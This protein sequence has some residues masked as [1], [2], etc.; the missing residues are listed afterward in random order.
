MNKCLVTKLK[1]SSNN[2]E[3]LKI[4]EMRI[5]L[6][7]SPS[8]T[9]GKCFTL[10]F[11]ET[12]TINILGEGYF[13]DS[14]YSE[15]KGNT[16]VCNKDVPTRVYVSNHDMEIS[17][18]NKYALTSFFSNDNDGASSNR[19]I[20]AYL[21]LDSLK[22]SKDAQFIVADG[23]HTTGNIDSL[24]ELSSLIYLNLN[25]S[26]A[27][28]N[29]NALKNLVK[30][31]YLSLNNTNFEGNID[32][33][34]GLTSI[35]VLSL[36]NTKLSGNI[37]S[38]KELSKLSSLNIINTNITGSIDSLSK[39]KNLIGFSLKNA[40]SK[41]TGSINS[42]NDFTRLSSISIGYA[43]L[44]G[45]LALLPSTVNFVSLSNNSESVFT[46][47]TRSSSAKVIAIE[48][49]PPIVNIDKMLQDQAACQ[50]GFDGSSPS[51][52]K[53]ISATGTRSSASD[54]A[55]QTLQSKGYT[56][57]ITHA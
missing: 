9:S 4:G 3:L 12:V 11:K 24:K 42:F 29:I 32:A 48:G 13:T 26:E 52:L 1:G 38:I 45:D 10:K 6:A 56:V 47:T 30:L 7:K 14:A 8:T 5:K 31:S 36:N 23:L 18:P 35:G 49:A 2:T 27:T 43:K 17:I 40:N 41:Y 15:N 57:S 34:K 16:L 46:W 22:Y 25:N 21:D 33:F 28:G 20:S 37:D 51:Y 44:T 55:V 39:M 53:I 54:A 50:I 19:V